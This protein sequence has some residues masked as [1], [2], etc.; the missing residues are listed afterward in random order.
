MKNTIKIILLV[1][2]VAALIAAVFILNNKKNPKQELLSGTVETRHIDVASKIPG[3]LDSILVNEGDM[4]KKGEILAFLE[5]KEMEAKVEQARGA[6]KAAD[7]KYAM[8][9]NGARPQE[10]A[11]A[12]KAYLQA[13]TQVD[14][15]E[16]TSKRISNLYLD[17]VV[18][19]QEFDQIQTQYNAA[20]ELADAALAKYD[21]VK[22]GARSEDKTAA[23]SIFY[24]A[25]NAYREA[26]AYAEELK[27]KSPVDG[28]VEKLI[29]DPGE[30][31]GAGYP[32]ITLIVPNDLW[33]IVQVK[34]D[35]MNRFR[36]G[37]E[38]RGTV[39]AL[40]NESFPFIVTYISPMADFATWRPTNQRGEFDIRTF[41]IHL[42]PK[43]SIEGLRAGMTVN[44]SL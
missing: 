33:V 32:V 16:K 36:K 3:R 18:S 22:E 15:L 9:R 23:Q 4:V 13:K 43:D 24:Q 20:K 35:R 14:F 2:L 7:A 25:E 11:A 6:M 5:S 19:S 27:L 30:I 42:R 40:N 26:L 31:I 17:S 10:L 41:E 34:E 28:E 12:Q 8:A 37:A 29:S 21:L 38:F 44:F 1:P 39:P